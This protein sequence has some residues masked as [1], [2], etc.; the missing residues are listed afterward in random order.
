MK[1]KRKKQKLKKYRKIEKTYIKNV[2]KKTEP[3][4]ADSS[5]IPQKTMFFW[6]SENSLY[7]VSPRNMILSKCISH[8]ATFGGFLT[9]SAKTLLFLTSRKFTI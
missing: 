2:K 3:R 9:H 6:L 5:S 4:V 7:T 8:R 1:K